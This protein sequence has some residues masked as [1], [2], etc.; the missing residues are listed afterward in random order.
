MTTTLPHRIAASAAVSGA[1]AA[2]LC[3]CAGA[4][5]GA[6]PEPASPSSAAGSAAASPAGDGATASPAPEGPSEAAG[7]TDLDACADADCE[8][9][10]EEGDEI[11][12]GGTQGM[13]RLVVEAADQEQVSFTAY[14]PGIMMSS[15]MGAPFDE[16]SALYLND[17]AIRVVEAGA[18][19]AVVRLSLE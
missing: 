17:V 3:G 8:V 12:M 19:H 7:G 14:G 2:V 6:S 9:R 18:D 4:D 16:E 13:D 1:L 11:P 10:I 15:S 5:G